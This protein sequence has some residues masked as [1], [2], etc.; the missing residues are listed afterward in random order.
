MIKEIVLEKVMKYIL[1]ESNRNKL[2]K[3]EQKEIESFLKTRT[4]V[5][6]KRKLLLFRYMLWEGF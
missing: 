4:G 6:L 5:I 3:K 2:N 1:N